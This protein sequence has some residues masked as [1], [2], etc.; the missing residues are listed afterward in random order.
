VCLEFLLKAMGRQILAFQC[1]REFFDCSVEFNA[2][3][4]KSIRSF[5]TFYVFIDDEV[6]VCVGL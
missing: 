1:D 6:R 2:C 4:D 5:L 3:H